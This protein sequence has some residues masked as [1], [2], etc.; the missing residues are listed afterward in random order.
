MRAVNHGL[1]LT[2]RDDD[3]HALDELRASGGGLAVV[4]GPAG[5]GR[6]RLLEAACERARADGALVLAATGAR[7]EREDRLGVVRQLLDRAGEPMPTAEPVFRALHALV[8]RLAA[9]AFVV[10]AVDDLQWADPASQDFF[11]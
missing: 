3:L 1:D 5:I 4:E 8:V 6:T 10:L 9:T 7:A 11:A 2:E